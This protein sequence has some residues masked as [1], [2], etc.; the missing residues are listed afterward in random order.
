MN[1]C[2]DENK[3]TYEYH[4]QVKNLVAFERAKK[5]YLP[6]LLALKNLAVIFAGFEQLAGFILS[7]KLCDLRDA[8]LV[9]YQPNS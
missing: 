1:L 8:T 2:L 4:Q 7:E 6:F 9:I 3:K 5:N